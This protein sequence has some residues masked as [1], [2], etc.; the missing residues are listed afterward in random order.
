MLYTSNLY[1]GVCQLFLNKTWWGRGGAGE[2]ISR[3]IIASDGKGRIVEK[4]IL[5]FISTFN[6]NLCITKS[7]RISDITRQVLPENE[8]LRQK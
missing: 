1:S 4:A 8:K 3:I 2:R 7:K 5:L 6:T